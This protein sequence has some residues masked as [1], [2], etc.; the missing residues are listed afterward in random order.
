MS[1][2]QTAVGAGTIV[3]LALVLAASADAATNLA[4]KAGPVGC[5]T[6]TGYSSQCL[7]GRGLVNPRALA[8]SP[9]GKNVY[10]A[11]DTWDSVSALAREPA[12]GSVA[13]I[14]SESGCLAS[15]E[16]LYPDCA[17]ARA[18]DGARD[19]A[20]SPDGKNVY[21]AAPDDG[22]VVILDR[23]PIDGH[24][25][26]SSGEDA[27]VTATGSDGCQEGRV[28]DVPTTVIVSPDGKNVYV[29]SEGLLGGI[30]VFERDP[31]TGDLSQ[32]PG[33]A[34]C[35]REAG[36]GCADG[37]SQMLGLESLE[38][39]P[40]GTTVYALSPARDAVTLYSRDDTSG[41]LT[42]MPPPS[43]CLVNQAADGCVV[44]TG[45]GEPRDLTF[46]PAGE[47]AYLAS[48]RRD[49]ILVFDHDQATGTL[50][51]KSGVAG[52][53]S[54]TGLSD[55]MQAGT[56]GDCAEGVAMDGISSVAVLPDGTAA[57]ATAIESAAVLVF[58]RA[59]DGTL[60]QRPGTAG[61]TTET[62]F[63]DSDLP[64]TAGTCADGRALLQANGVVASSDS[65]YAYASGH[66][67]GVASFDVVEP[68][69][70][71]PPAGAPPPPPATISPEC[72]RA[73]R[74]AR[75][76]ARRLKNLARENERRAR[77]AT[78]VTS[79][80]A[81]DRLNEAADR[82]RRRAK[83]MR[84]ELRKANANVRRLCA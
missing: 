73:L 43:G 3:I 79:E 39:S 81:R 64:W 21:V 55:P 44:A 47:N 77:K 16:F 82:G 15:T 26:Q 34:G 49:A 37:L 48:E 28:L 75:T 69:A 53:V 70:S 30:A 56:A 58:E 33:T 68:P 57:Y 84:L 11:S 54:D 42:P 32:D 80:A 9:D 10:V 62:G 60:T 24:L 17:D 72:A 18:L 31:D 46:S 41:A 23:D 22:A 83:R 50:S 74:E 61:C 35:V 67:G 19:V 20:V 8:L 25:T 6:E 1:S 14:D 71:G 7:D 78:F 66:L 13:P 2:K 65:K 29:G 51:Q 45:L 40:E 76:L 52:C 38:I 5:V 63:E 4:Q 12:D 36:N 59:P 27:C